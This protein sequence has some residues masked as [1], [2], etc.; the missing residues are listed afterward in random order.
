[1]ITSRRG[2]GLGASLRSDSS[3]VAV[4]L[5]EGSERLTPGEVTNTGQVLN[6]SRLAVFFGGKWIGGRPQGKVGGRAPP[7]FAQRTPLASWFWPTR[8]IFDTL[9]E[10]SERFT[11]GEV[12]N[13]GPTKSQSGTLYLG[14]G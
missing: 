1:M 2:A 3:C 11:P 14:L 9:G 8:V 13:T 6:K 5:G 12:T 7:T 4:L 10:G